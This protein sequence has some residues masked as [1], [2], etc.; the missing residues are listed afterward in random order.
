MRSEIYG[1]AAILGDGIS[2]DAMIAGKYCR[3]ADPGELSAH[4][5]EGSDIARRG[6]KGAIILAGKNFGCGSSREQA[7]LALKAAGVRAVAALSFGRIFF[8]N[9]INIGLPVMN[10]PGIPEI[11]RDGD[12]LVLD[13]GRGVI[14]NRTREIIKGRPLPEILMG[15]L[16][17]GGLAP[18]TKAKL[19]VFGKAPR[20]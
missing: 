13:I 4:I 20:P 12:E 11:L 1:R 15:I 2:T 18:Y 19:A 5:F 14:R 9:A 8:R 3:L 16:R 10:I 6:L 17:A 7:P